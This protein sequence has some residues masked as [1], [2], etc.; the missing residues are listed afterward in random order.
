LSA[1]RI[2]PFAADH[3]APA[4]EALAGRHGQHRQA[5][6]LVAAGDARPFLES[7][8]R[9]PGSSGAAAVRDGRVAAFAVAEVAESALFGRSAWIGHAGHAADDGELLREVYAAAAEGWAAAGAER[10][11]VLVPA[12]AAALEPWY[13]LGFAHMHVEALRPVTIERQPPPE[14][15]ALRLGTRAD[16]EVGEE[17]DFEIYRLQARSPSFSRLPLDRDA[18]RREWL[19]IDLREEGL[20][21]LV[22][23]ERG[24]IVGHTIIYRPEPVLGVPAD[25]AYLAS[26]AVLEAERGRG[27]G[28]ALLGEVMRRAAEAGYG[29]LFTNWRMTNLSASRFWPSQ[30]FVPIYYRLHRAIGNG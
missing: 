25:A 6:P 1:V 16:L 26:T 9:T 29:S 23:E 3:L 4:A 21:Y 24:R 27:I 30:G 17:I 28:A 14:G 18:R 5:L 19:E 12:F 22:A 20:C 10:H 7:F 8:W 2:E 13:R 15:V 11:Y